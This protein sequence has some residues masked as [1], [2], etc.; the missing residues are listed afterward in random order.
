M[1]HILYQEFITGP[2]EFFGEQKISALDREDAHAPTKRSP[3]GL[4][5]LI[6]G[7][8]CVKS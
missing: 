2:V 3:K 6:G 5:F 7:A 1:L 8:E 4:R